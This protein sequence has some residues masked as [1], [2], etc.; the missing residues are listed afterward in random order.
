[1]RRRYV[2]SN[3]REGAGSMSLAARHFALDPASNAS[4]ALR[5]CLLRPRASKHSLPVEVRRAIRATDA[6][7]AAY[8][9]PNDARLN[10]VY[11]PGSLRMVRNPDGSLRRLLPGERQSWDDATIN[12]GVCVPWPWGGDRC[13]DRWGVRV[14]R[15]QLLAGIDDATDFTVGYSY[16]IRDR[17]SYRAEDVVS[18][19]ARAW[20]ALYAPDTAVMEGGAWQAERTLD[21]FRACG[22][23]I[24]SAK[25][26]PHSKLIENFWNR[27]WTVLAIETE[28]QVGRYRGEMQRETNLLMRCQAGS[29]DPRRCF[30]LLEHALG[31]ID[32][33]FAFLA[34]DRIES[35]EYGAWVPAEAHAAGIAARAAEGRPLLPLAADVAHLAWPVREQRK[36]V[37]GMVRVRTET[38]LG[39]SRPYHFASDELEACNGALVNVHFDPWASPLRAVCT[40]A[41][42]FRDMPAGSQICAAVPC[43]DSAP[44][45][46]HAD[47]G[48]W[49]VAFGD[50]IAAA[51]RARRAAAAAVRR[52][53]RSMSLDGRRVQK[54]VSEIRATEKNETTLGIGQPSAEPL[55]TPD[56]VFTEPDFAALEKEAGVLRSA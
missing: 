13:S 50:G 2:R 14:G 32:R 55:A 53:H 56:P 27:L 4:D 9:N 17:S 10:G 22:V 40:L 20:L 3:L 52:E 41:A 29:L 1:M 16:V 45:L 23:R 54:W 43:I 31:A 18:A 28:G 5:A 34:H 8:R 51:L 47:A 49:Q 38:P 44:E 46:L 6:A 35:K 7:V 39:G 30:P 37:R 36:I 26:R 24:I 33:G 11:A 21:F 25:G 15:F 12:F 19:I 48:R 42:P